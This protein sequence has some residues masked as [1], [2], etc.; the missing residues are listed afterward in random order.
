LLLS[1]YRLPRSIANLSTGTLNTTTTRRT[2][3]KKRQE[4]RKRARGKKGTVYEEEYLV[5]SIERLIERVNSL[6]AE[7]ERL[8][9]GLVRRGM[10][11]R[12]MAVERAMGEVVRGCEG[13]VGEVYGGAEEG[14]KEDEG[15]GQ[16]M[17]GI[18]GNGVG[19]VNGGG[20][21]EAAFRPMGADATLWASM[22]EVSKKREAPV[23]KAFAK[24]SL[25]G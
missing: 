7:V 10:R 16:G 2:S 17:Q 6:G 24:M 4:E 12:G 18:D 8:V 5:N 19:G 3:K 14:G 23:V 20:G 11:E 1:A 9:E 13:A 21:G 15:V 25:L 22:E